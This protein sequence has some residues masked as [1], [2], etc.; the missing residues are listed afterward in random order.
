MTTGQYLIFTK[1]N[2]LLLTIRSRWL[3]VKMIAV[4]KE[5]KIEKHRFGLDKVASR[6]F[7]N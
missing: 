3:K 7:T 5:N 4:I 2:K 6:V 1:P